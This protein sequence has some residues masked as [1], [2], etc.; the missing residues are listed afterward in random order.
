M[1]QLAQTPPR[2]PGPL[3][4]VPLLLLHPEVVQA[5]AVPGARPRPV[6][7][8]PVPKPVWAGPV[9]VWTRPERGADPIWA[10]PEPDPGH[11]G[12]RGHGLRLFW[13]PALPD[14]GGEA[15][16]RLGF[17]VSAQLMG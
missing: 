4:L 11:P 2:C 16:G 9:R 7:T 13:E 15:A 14:Q 8:Q 3:A 6:R 5:A 1:V 10:R 17:L 12:D